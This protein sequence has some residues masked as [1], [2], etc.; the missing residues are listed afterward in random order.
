[1]GLVHVII[2][3]I[4]PGVSS[5]LVIADGHHDLSKG[6]MALFGIE[7]YQQVDINTALN[8]ILTLY[9]TWRIS[10]LEFWKKQQLKAKWV[11]NMLGMQQKF[12]YVTRDC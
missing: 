5:R 6:R 2:A 4:F 7:R 10:A 11:H 12:I 3:E 1:M 8:T 9:S